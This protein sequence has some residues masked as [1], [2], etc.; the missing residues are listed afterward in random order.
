M[1]ECPHKNLKKQ[2]V[3]EGS[4]YRCTDCPQKFK[5]EPWDGKVA[6]REALR[7]PGA[8]TIEQ[9]LLHAPFGAGGCTC[10]WW[11]SKKSNDGFAAQEEWRQHIR[12][13]LSSK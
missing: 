6:V 8:L 3:G 12:A 1:S 7:E 13:A 11:E 4:W 10:G 2:I 5:A 9:V